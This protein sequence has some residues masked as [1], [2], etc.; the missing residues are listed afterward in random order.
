[1]IRPKPRPAQGR[2]RA[3]ATALT[4]ALLFGAHAGLR[5]LPLPAFSSGREVIRELDALILERFAAPDPSESSPEAESEEVAEDEP[6][7]PLDAVETVSFEQEVGTAMEELERRF[8]GEE[9]DLPPVGQRSADPGDGSA[10]GIE[11]VAA[12]D[13]FESLF[14]ASDEVVVGRA[15]RGRTTQQRDQQ[16]GLG[17]GI[18]ERLVDSDEAVV[19]DS[20]ATVGPDVTVQTAADRT[21]PTEGTP[22]VIGAFEPESFDGSEADRLGAWLRMHPSELPVGVRVHMNFE[23]SFLTASVPFSSE[24][25]RWELFLMYNESLRELHIVLVEDDRSVYLIDRGFQERSRSLREGN[26]RRSGGEIVAVDSRIAAPS[27]DESAD[28]FN[29]FLSWWEVAKIDVGSR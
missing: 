21:E 9:S 18:N 12:N 15:G 20:D 4:I 26:V 1:M 22:V 14:G 17:I 24:G 23:P 10:S 2:Q 11:D 8:G 7:E 29:V 3:V 16:G 25:R 5:A 6:E 28:F 19:P 13:R 27:N